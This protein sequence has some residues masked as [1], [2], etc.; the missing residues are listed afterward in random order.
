MTSAASIGHDR[1]GGSNMML[2][3]SLKLILLAF[4]IL[5][6]SLADFE[7]GRARAVLASVNQAFNGKI[8]AADQVP[9]IAS[10]LGALPEVEAKM[11]EVGSLFEA[12]AP[13]ADA[14]S[15]RR[16]NMVR[17]DLPVTA[18]FRPAGPRLRQGREVLLQRLAQALGKGPKAA[19]RY[20]LEVLVGTGTPKAAEAAAPDGSPSLELRRAAVLAARLSAEGVPVDGI[21]TG[22]RPGAPDSLRFIVRLRPE[23]A[24]A[25]GSDGREG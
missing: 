10:T 16:A 13:L 21:S 18:L 15:V 14:K 24:T 12:I 9:T 22:L 19:P 6:N 23:P 11:R 1:Q 3:L 7:A 8:E 20:L 17:I 25:I 4:F 5:L 2:L